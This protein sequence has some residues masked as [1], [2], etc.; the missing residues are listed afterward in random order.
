MMT[1]PKA[2]NQR[3]SK[4][5]VCLRFLDAPHPSLLNYLA[6]YPGDTPEE[7][8]APNDTKVHMLSQIHPYIKLMKLPTGGQFA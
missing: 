6:I 1:Q 5:Y 8:D 4:C 7:L 2:K 3:A